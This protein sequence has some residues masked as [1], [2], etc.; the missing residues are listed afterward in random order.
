MEDAKYVSS[1]CIGS[2][3]SIVFDN[4]G[5]SETYKLDE[6]YYD[7]IVLLEKYDK[8]IKL[9]LYHNKKNITDYK[10]ILRSNGNEIDKA[11]NEEELRKVRFNH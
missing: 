5:N 11:S 7:T 6:K 3:C 1:M 9:N 4:N 2:S 10:I 8:Y